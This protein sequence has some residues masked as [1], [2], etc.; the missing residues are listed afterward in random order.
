MSRLRPWLIPTVAAALALA[1]FIAGVVTWRMMPDMPSCS[2]NSLC[3]ELLPSHRL[4]PLRAE[5]LW[6]AS[7]VFALIAAGT[8]LRNWRR[9]AA[10]PAVSA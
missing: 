6:A 5:L 3:F 7:A 10:A 2:P 9:P 1:F 8:L 4:H